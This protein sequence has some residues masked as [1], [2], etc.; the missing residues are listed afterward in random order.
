MRAPGRGSGL[1][2]A[3][4]VNSV[5]MGGVEEHVRQIAE[6]FRARGADVTVICPEAPAIDPLARAVELTG[7]KVVRLDLS[8]TLGLSAAAARFA[9]L[10]R[11]LRA[12]KVQVLHIHLTGYHGG[13]WAVLAAKF[14]RISATI[15]TIQIAPHQPESRAVRA[16]RGVMNLVVDRFIAVA[17]APKRQLVDWAG[18]SGEKTAVIPNAVELQR[19]ERVPEGARLEVR[20]QFGIPADAPLLGSLARLDPQKGLAHLLDAMPAVL[21][22]VPTVH[23]LLVGDGVLRASLE[24]QSRELGLTGCVHFAGQQRD[25]P[26]YLTTFDIFVLPSLFEGLPLS[27]LEAMA[28]GLPVVATAVDGTPEATEDGVTGY[29]VPPADPAALAAAL[30]KLLEKPDTAARMSA[31]ARIRARSFSLDALIDRLSRLYSEVL[32]ARA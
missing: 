6:G 3:L 4:F 12:Q 7:A 27:I 2:V 29:L 5:I 26:R 18:L 28:A 9:E 17:Q 10:V 22:R 15:C 32:A 11:L 8:R 14:A 19:Y 1:R 30:A 31:E 25:V 23:L 20:N 13:R 24:Q 16:E 21:A